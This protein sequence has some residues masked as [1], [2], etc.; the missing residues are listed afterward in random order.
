[1]IA[2]NIIFAP[3]QKIYYSV[4]FLFSAYQL[5]CS[6]NNEAF[7]VNDVG[8]SSLMSSVTSVKKPITS[9]D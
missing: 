2:T 4:Y 6:R 1:M 7:V 8:R 3:R 5:F 9:A